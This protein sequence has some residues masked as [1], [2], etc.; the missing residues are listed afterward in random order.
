MKVNEAIHVTW[1]TDLVS[2]KQTPVLSLTAKNTKEC[3]PF[4]IEDERVTIRLRKST[5]L[6][7]AK[8]L[9]KMAKELK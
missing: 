2:G 8:L 3:E 9:T 5:A 7:L 6:K 1:S 4:L